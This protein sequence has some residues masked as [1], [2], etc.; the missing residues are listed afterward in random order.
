MHAHR[1]DGLGGGILAP[2]GLREPL[3]AD[4]FVRVQQQHRQQRSA[5]LAADR[6]R[7]TVGLHFER[8]KDPEL[9][10][11]LAVDGID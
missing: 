3:G 11:A 9:H 8:T 7:V 1:L 6:D 10:L 4:R 5:L 2:Q